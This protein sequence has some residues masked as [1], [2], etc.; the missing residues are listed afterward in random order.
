MSD[1][2][3]RFDH[4]LARLDLPPGPAWVAVSGGG[5][6]LALL[7]L[8]ARSP[9]ARHLV[10]VVAHVDHGIHRESGSIADRVALAA[11][12]LGL[13][14]RSTRLL[15]GAEATETRAR[16][17]RYRWLLEAAAAEGALLFTA[18]TRDDQVETVLMRFLEG[19]GLA[20]LAGMSPLSTAGSG[21]LLPATRLV[22]PLLG[23]PRSGLR[24]WLAALGVPAWE[25]P[26]NLDPRHLRGWLRSHL[27]PM[28]ESREP[29]ARQHILRVSDGARLNRA[30]WEA[31]L[32][33][34]PLDYRRVSDG[35]SV[36]S[37]PLRGYPFPL[38][39]SLVATAARQGGLSLGS[40]RA[41]R[42][43]ALVRRGR[44]GARL[45][46]G[47]GWIAELDRERLAVVREGPVPAAAEIGAGT[48]MI[49][50]GSWAVRWVPA[51]AVAPQRGGWTAWLVPGTYRLTGWM[52]GDRIRPLGGT[53][54]RLVVRCLQDAGVPRYRRPGWPVVRRGSEVIWVP[55]VCRSGAA[56]P[57]DGVEATRIDVEDS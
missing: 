42:V 55:G 22:R 11:R 33:V 39:L 24:Q 8:L 46:L 34:L 17:G 45:E 43:V 7:H 29:D 9:A 1:L 19:S 14:F 5:D 41:A 3:D 50:W 31:L 12:D 2:Q 38:A 25:D 16:E 13:A 27:L 6:S 51:P 32:Q 15:L 57:G 30:A 49:R 52:A 53:G 35:I 20:G 56:L 44:T 18:H 28:A 4:T 10:L 37:V 40:R 23:E 48:G 36:A 26:S 21:R 54:S 47:G